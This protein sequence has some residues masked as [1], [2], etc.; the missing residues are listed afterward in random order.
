MLNNWTILQLSKMKQVEAMK[1]A[2]RR[3]LLIEV[4]SGDRRATP[5][6]SEFLNILG[7]GLV[8]CG[9]ALQRRYGT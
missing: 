8:A 6:R 7:K 1:D 3:R 4:H 2:Q 9:M 5:R